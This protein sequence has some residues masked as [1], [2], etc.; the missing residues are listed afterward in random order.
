MYCLTFNCL[1]TE[2]KDRLM[3][4]LYTACLPLRCNEP[5]SSQ[6][7]SGARFFLEVHKMIWLASLLESNLFWYR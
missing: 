5:E 7:G 1:T 6:I 3:V 2:H 4:R